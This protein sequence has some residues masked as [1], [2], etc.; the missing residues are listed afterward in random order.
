MSNNFGKVSLQ[1]KK[2]M[3]WLETELPENISKIDAIKTKN[4]QRVHGVAVSNTVLQWC[5]TQLQ[6]L[7]AQKKPLKSSQMICWQKIV[8]N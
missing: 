2:L 7:P 8:D 5:T 4:Q 1:Y 3:G 6:Y